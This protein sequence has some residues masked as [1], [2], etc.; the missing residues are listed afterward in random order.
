M[1]PNSLIKQ[2][3]LEHAL[4]LDEARW[5]RGVQSSTTV[6]LHVNLWNLLH[7]VPIL[8]PCQHNYAMGAIQFIL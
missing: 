2:A 4:W 1:S 8:Q 6:T 7:L 3:F 5:G